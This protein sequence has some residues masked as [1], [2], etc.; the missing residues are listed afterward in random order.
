MRPR[1]PMASARTAATRPWP[2]ACR[3]GRRRPASRLA[4]PRRRA[5][6]PLYSRRFPKQLFAQHWFGSARVE[7]DPEESLREF[8]IVDDTNRLAVLIEAHAELRDVDA[9]QKI[10]GIDIR[11]NLSQQ[12][13]PCG[14]L[15]RAAIAE[16]GHFFD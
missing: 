7:P 3:T 8:A 13:A 10:A 14:A 9:R 1:R 11:K 12:F 6:P 5:P 15:L 4:E 16:L 2:A